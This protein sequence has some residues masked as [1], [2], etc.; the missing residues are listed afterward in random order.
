MRQFVHKF[1]VI[2]YA[3]ISKIFLLRPLLV[4]FHRIDVRIDPIFVAVIEE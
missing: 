2:Y 4:S 3:N 1:K